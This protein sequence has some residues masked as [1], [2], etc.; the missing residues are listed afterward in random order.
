MMKNGGFSVGSGKTKIDEFYPIVGS[1]CS[2]CSFKSDE[3]D[4]EE[5][6]KEGLNGADK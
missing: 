5:G 1:I 6:C 2:G 3:G 4:C